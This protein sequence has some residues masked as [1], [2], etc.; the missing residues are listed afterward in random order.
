GCELEASVA[1]RRRSSPSYRKPADWRIDM[2]LPLSF[3]E[4][5]PKTDLHVHLD[6]SL[7][8]TTLLELAETQGIA[9]PAAE[10]EALAKALHF[11]EPAGSLEEYLK[12]FEATVQVMQTESALERVSYELAE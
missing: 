7:R 11:G 8:L 12:A 10:P 5:L 4:K 6:G 9:L 2:T 3:I 1:F